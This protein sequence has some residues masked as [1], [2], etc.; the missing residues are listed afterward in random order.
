MKK[1]KTRIALIIRS[2]LTCR[3]RSAASTSS[4]TPLSPLP[5]PRRRRAHPS[6]SVLV[7]DATGAAAAARRPPP[8]PPL[9]G[10]VL[11]VREMSAQVRSDFVYLFFFLKSRRVPLTK[12]RNVVYVRYVGEFHC[13]AE[14][15]G[16]SPFQL[17]NFKK[18]IVPPPLYLDYTGSCRCLGSGLFAEK[19]TKKYAIYRQQ[20]NPIALMYSPNY[21][22]FGIMRK[23]PFHGAFGHFLRFL[24]FHQSFFK[25]QHSAKDTFCKEI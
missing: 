24:Q 11:S 9:G 23:D 21:S 6:S 4:V 20:K 10:T 18:S 13:C 5:S 22:F 16:K 14:V 2:W 19:G 15:Q 1:K 25:G 17:H 7:M 12:T 3:Q 8:L